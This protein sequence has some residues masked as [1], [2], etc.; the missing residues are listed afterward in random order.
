MTSVELVGAPEQDL[1]GKKTSELQ[2]GIGVNGDYITG[3]LHHVIG[4]TGFNGTVPA[5]QEGYYFAMQITP[6]EDAELSS[7]TLNVW[8]KEL[9]PED[10]GGKPI[11][12]KLLKDATGDE[13]S[14]SFTVNANWGSGAVQQTFTYKFR[15]D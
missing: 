9:D 8:G 4:Y 11:L 7:S 14:G 5:E 3:T 10:D 6:P 1:L 13:V 12:I 2:Y 15:L